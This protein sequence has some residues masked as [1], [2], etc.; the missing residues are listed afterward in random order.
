MQIIPRSIGKLQNL[1]TLDLK[2]TLVSE[3]P[4]EITKLKKLQYLLVYS[5]EELAAFAPF[6]LTKG[7]SAP[8]G[9]GVLTSL[10]K[11]SCVKARGGRRKNVVQELGELSK[12]TRLGVRDLK[13]DDAEQLCHSLVKMTDLQSLNVV[14][15]SEYEIID[16]EF[17]SSPPPLLRSLFIEGCLKKL[18]SWLH[19]LTSLTT[20]RLAWTR[21]KSSPLIALQNLPNLVKLE[22]TN[23]FDGETL[24]F[25]DKGFPKLKQ[26]SIA[27]LENLK[28]VSMNGLAMPGL[29]RLIIDGCKHL[30]WQSLLV[31]IRGLTF[32][33]YLRFDEMP[34]EFVLAFFPYS[35]SEAMRDGVLQDC[36]EEVMERSPEVYFLWWEEDN[37]EWY[38]LSPHCYD[39]IKQRVMSRDEVLPDDS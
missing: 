10:Q 1:E 13:K 20:L 33:T 26:L 11:L 27:N 30:G 39:V 19:M 15:E 9:I 3:L 22:L 4:L 37:W 23:A 7:F 16:L 2:H 34:E 36:Y 25:G 5:Y 38:D 24:V 28:F 6:G 35:S 14:A 32:L 17:L 21:L 8:E 29:R 18:P 31:V 12:L